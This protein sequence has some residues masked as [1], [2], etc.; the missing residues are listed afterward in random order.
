MST[1]MRAQAL[2][3]I[4]RFAAT[5]E[6]HLELE[7]TY[8]VSNP[9]DGLN[10]NIIDDTEIEISVL[11]GVDPLRGCFAKAHAEERCILN[12]WIASPVLWSASLFITLRMGTQ[13]CAY[14]RIL[15]AVRAPHLIA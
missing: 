10:G 11:G 14:A 1:T 5:G 2:P 9:F 6:G 12:P 7:N 4:F 3:G 13:S 8:F 15:G